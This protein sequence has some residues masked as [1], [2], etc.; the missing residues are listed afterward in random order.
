MYLLDTDVLSNLLK[1]SPPVALLVRLAVVP[2]QQQSTASITVGEIACGAHRLGA[3]GQVFLDK[4]D[5]LLLANLS[6]LPFDTE[7]ARWYGSVRAGLER[8]GTPL[9]DADMRIASIALARGL[10]VVTGNTRHFSAVPGLTVENW[11]E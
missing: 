2:A 9:G 7:A 11:L 8:R 1:R 10:T 6:V 5:T 4:L 3:R